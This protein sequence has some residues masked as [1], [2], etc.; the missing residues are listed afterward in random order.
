MTRTTEDPGSRLDATGLLFGALT[1]ASVVAAV[2]VAAEPATTSEASLGWALAVLLG[3]AQLVWHRHPTALLIGSAAIVVAYHLVGAPAVGLVWP[4][5]IPYLRTSMA[6]RWLP[7]T[8]VAGAASLGAIAW[9]TVVEEEPALQV[10]VGEL[11]GLVVVGLVLA[12]GEASWQRR[13]WEQEVQAR[14]ADAEARTRLDLEHALYDQ[15]LALAADLHDVTGHGLVVIG[16]Q[17]RNADETLDSDPEA[18]R[19]AIA[20]ALTAHDRAVE[21]TT[22]AVR[23]LRSSVSSRDTAP[24]L[25]TATLSALDQ[26]VETA[27]AGGVALVIRGEEVDVSE[28]TSAVAYRICQEALTNTLRH[29]G[30]TRAS[31]S[32]EPAPD[33]RIH[34]TYVDNGQWTGA[35]EGG[36]GVRGMHDRARSVGGRVHLTEAPTGALTVE[37]WLPTGH[38]QL[39]TEVM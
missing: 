6:G 7:A 19:A 4:L 35:V 32:I 2:L 39:V 33:S 17:L 28:A 9:R 38:D 34:I 18:C 3:T 14:L 24:R 37:A 23:L 16:L 5:L 21:Q 10:V 30:A 25:P 29:A 8:A 12:V 11:Q 31:L 13:R 22:A 20:S 27:A 36:H 1:L 15:R 26:L